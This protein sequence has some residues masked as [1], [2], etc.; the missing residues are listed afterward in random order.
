[1]FTGIIKN[2]HADVLFS[3]ASP[4]EGNADRQKRLADISELAK[5]ILLYTQLLF[6]GK[7]ASSL[8]LER[9]NCDNE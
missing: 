1:V 7:Y 9:K 6:R 2:I 4:I 3:R 8:T 5:L